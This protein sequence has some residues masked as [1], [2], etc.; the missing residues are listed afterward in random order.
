MNFS[1]RRWK[2]SD[3]SSLV[4][5]INNVHI[6]SKLTDDTVLP[7]TEDDAKLYM[8][9]ENP[10]Y[11][12]SYAVIYDNSVIGGIKFTCCDAPNNIVYRMNFWLD[13]EFWNDEEVASVLKD[14]VRFCFF[15]FPAIKL[16]ANV[17]ESDEPIQK[18]L[19]AAGFEREAVLKKSILKSGVVDNLHIFSI[20]E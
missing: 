14:M 12:Q 3:T 17:M 6:W 19:L 13:A 5:Y 7:F 4:N 18:A 9:H 20:T 1:T 11:S 2:A 16:V 8:Q 15:H 10:A